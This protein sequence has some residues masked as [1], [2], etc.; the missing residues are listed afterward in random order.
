[1]GAVFSVLTCFFLAISFFAADIAFSADTETEQH[2]TD[3]SESSQVEKYEESIEP[4]EE[5]NDA[6]ESTLPS[7]YKLYPGSEEFDDFDE[8]EEASYCS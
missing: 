7:I 2:E 8:E 5:Q 4:T 3:I 6:G 1:M